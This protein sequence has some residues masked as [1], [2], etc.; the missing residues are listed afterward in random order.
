MA[1]PQSAVVAAARPSCGELKGQIGNRFVIVRCLGRG[2]MGEVYCARDTRLKKLVAIKRM[3]AA[4]RDDPG[5]RERFL[6]EA[7][8]ASQLIDRNIAACYD[9]VEEDG[10]LLL[11]MEYVE[12]QTLRQRLERRLPLDESLNIAVQS[13]SGVAGAHEHR[14]LHCDLKPE[15]IMLTPSGHVKLLDFGLA[16]HFVRP[17][18]PTTSASGLARAGGTPGYAAPEVL[19]EHPVDERADIFSLGIVFYE[20]LTGVRPFHAETSM[21]MAARI[22]Q[23][24][25]VPPRRL[26]AKIPLELDRIVLRMLR[27]DPQQRYATAAEV[28]NDLRR[29]RAVKSRWLLLARYVGKA[30]S[31]KRSLRWVAVVLAIFLPFAV[32]QVRAWLRHT[33]LGN[34][35]PKNKHLAVLPFK[36]TGADPSRRAF[37]DGLAATLSARFASLSNR[38]SLEIVAPGEILEQQ[39]TTAQEARRAFGANLV[40]EGDMSWSGDA[41]RITYSITNPVTQRQLRADTITASAGDPFILE[42]RVAQSALKSLELELDAQEL[43]QFGA[44][45]TLQPAAYDFYLQGRGY[46]QDFHKPENLENAIA[47][48]QHALARDPNFALAY[49]GLGEAYW[50]QFLLTHEANWVEMSLAS[51]QKAVALAP[52]IAEG[53]ECLGAASNGTG[54]YEQAEEHFQNAIRLN[55]KDEAARLGLADSLERRGRTAEAEQVFR[56]AIDLRPNYWAVYNYLG[57]F[58]WRQ[59]RY[60]EAEQMFATV[61]RLE[62]DNV[63]GFSNLGAMQILED[64][65]AEAIPTFERAVAISP[66]SDA[67][68]NLGTAYFYTRRYSEAAGAYAKAAELDPRN[69]LIQGNLGDAY[70]AVPGQ[71]PAASDAYRKAIALATEEA[72][73]NPRDAS[74]PIKLAKYHAMLGE[75]DQ[76]LAALAR[77]LKMQPHDPEVLFEIALVHEQT[78]DSEQA[79]AWLSKS[80]AAGF[81]LASVRDDPVFAP[82]HNDP[83][84]QK[85]M[86]S[87]AGH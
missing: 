22:L 26:N 24:D 60:R 33:V 77:G 11:V 12:G 78:G 7:E 29:L 42:D 57:I 6:Q 71:R 68:S 37:S 21:G 44:R 63:R 30:V 59:G 80:L 81:S 74:L 3:S 35:I 15:N 55:P 9:V 82:L 10:E 2:G 79:V 50:H 67:Y 17:A 65:Y 14:V 49:A 1:D 61:T 23:D 41:M 75:K 52:T 69:Y 4:L 56:K 8:R 47:V 66:S 83:R 20:M 84:F 64:R 39:V 25:P 85:L 76:A 43:N 19:C 5:C 16:R 28:L 38:H 87:S 46:L 73:V 86:A 45:G 13:A 34:E 18:D 32:P 70:H 48:F 53:H 58:Y 72:R 62:P 27:K 51:C 36:V 54:K 40:V 31:S